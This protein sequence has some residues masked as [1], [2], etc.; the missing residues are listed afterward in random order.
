[1]S[2]KRLGQQ[3]LSFFQLFTL[4]PFHLTSKDWGCISEALKDGRTKKEFP[5]WMAF[6]LLL[7][8][9]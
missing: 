3:F 2:E 1:M 9:R 4:S 5:F 7:V 8:K 6:D